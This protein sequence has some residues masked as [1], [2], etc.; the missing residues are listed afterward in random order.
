MFAYCN[1]NPISNIDPNGE[2]LIAAALILLGGAVLGGIVG[3]IVASK[4]AEQQ[5]EEASVGEIVKGVA[6]GTALGVAGFGLGLSIATV[7][8][9]VM[10]GASKAVFLGAA[11]TSVA[12]LGRLA[13]NVIPMILLPLLGIEMEGDYLEYVE[14]Y[15]NT[16]ACF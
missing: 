6:V 5:D 15:N 16:T 12:A 11:S 9:I 1:N 14:P 8:S 4:I 2:S 10:Y 3:G 13:Y 7:P